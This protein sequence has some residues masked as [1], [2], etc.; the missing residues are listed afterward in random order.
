M[1]IS[2]KKSLPKCSKCG[3]TPNCYRELAS[4]AIRFDLTNAKFDEARS[5][6][7]I[8]R[9][10][11]NSGAVQ[12]GYTNLRAVGFSYYSSEDGEI[13]IDSELEQADNIG[14]VEAICECGHSWILRNHKK[15]DSLISLHGFNRANPFKS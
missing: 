8:N 15:I 7:D 14:K 5:T 11:V 4:T 1:T 10:R 9:D 12:A 2:A 3:E 13:S 6:M